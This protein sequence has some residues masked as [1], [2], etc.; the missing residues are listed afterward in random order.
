MT[1]AA[2]FVIGAVSVPAAFVGAQGDVFGTDELEDSLSTTIGTSQSLQ[3]TVGNVIN[4]AL[5]LLGIVAVVIILRGGFIWMTAGGDS[6]KV[7]TARNSIFA[8]VIGIAIIFSAWAITT[9][10]LDSLYDATGNSGAGNGNL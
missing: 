2:A 6:G 3:T 8:G 7:D 1:I 9:F 10:V 4:V 5:S